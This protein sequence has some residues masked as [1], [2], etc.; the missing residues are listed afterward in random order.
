MIEELCTANYAGGWTFAV[1]GNA[2]R[3]ARGCGCGIYPI[4]PQTEVV[5]TVVQLFDK[6]VIEKGRVFHVESEHS[7]LSTTIGVSV[8]GARAFTATSSNGALYMAENVV[9]ASLYRLPIVMQIVNRTLGPEW[10]IW[11]EQGDSLIF[12]DWGW[13]QV[14][15]EN[16]QELVDHILMAFYISENHKVMLPSMICVDAF[17]LSHTMMPV[18]LPSQE[19]ADEYL[20]LLDVPQRLRVEKP[21]T[22]G[23][24]SLPRV[25]ASHRLDM[26]KD[27]Q[28]VFDIY[29]E[30]QDRFEKIFDRRPEDPVTGYYHDDADIL[31][32]TSS[33][34]TSTA[35][36][37]V[38]KRRKNG[39]KIGLIKIK[40]F[41]PFPSEAVI[42]LAKNAEKIAILDRNT[43]LGAPSGVCG[44]FAQEIIAALGIAG[45]NK[46]VQSYLIGLGGMDV[47]FEAVDEVVDDIVNRTKTEKSIWKGL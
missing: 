22:I 7:A 47:P 31:L 46:F 33:T 6:G 4:T 40:M 5:E 10:N 35:K 15:C 36:S 45:M 41:R 26:E 11:A 30:A 12:R 19:E 25:T 21:F 42:E 44:I 14:Y 32:V 27:I 8:E 29:T 1:S 20:P 23:G 43:M 16:N 2:N 17:I 9:S 18:K 3:K 28:N 24:L 34:I 37:V 38:D 13:I 39:E